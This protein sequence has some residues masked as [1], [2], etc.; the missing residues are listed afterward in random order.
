[1]SQ[2][3]FRATLFIEPLQGPPPCLALTKALPHPG[4][5]LGPRPRIQLDPQ[6][7]RIDQIKGRALVDWIRTRTETE[8]GRLPAS[9][10]A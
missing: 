9:V 5:P 2:A 4:F 7:R 8:P 3:P 10:M 1:M 6:L